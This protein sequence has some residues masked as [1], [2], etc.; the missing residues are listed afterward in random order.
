M[1]L[2]TS[3][4][5]NMIREARS[6][7]VR[8]KQGAGFLDLT[9]KDQVNVTFPFEAQSG[10]TATEVILHANHGDSEWQIVKQIVRTGDKIQFV[11]RKNIYQTAIERSLGLD[12]YS[13][14][15]RV[16]RKRQWFEVPVVQRLIPA[17][18][19]AGVK[20]MQ[21]TAARHATV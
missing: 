7:I 10:V 16:E 19:P 15:L 17:T 20:M 5:R 9:L 1:L 11:F 6:A 12:H 8:A 18:A 14:H 3:D 4:I 2:I 21:E 13:L